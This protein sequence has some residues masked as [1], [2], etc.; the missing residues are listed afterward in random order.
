MADFYEC[1]LFKKPLLFMIE[2]KHMIRLVWN[3]L[4]LRLKGFMRLSG[5][6]P[7][8]NIKHLDTFVEIVIFFSVFPRH[9][10]PQGLFL[11]M[12]HSPVYRVRL[13]RLIFTVLADVGSP[14]FNGKEPSLFLI[15][16][17]FFLVLCTEV[18]T[19]TKII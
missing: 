15:S 5:N 11:L 19:K 8:I 3:P 4:Y 9:Q 14:L 2:V 12:H 7:N 1:L 18:C 16:P 17:V 13:S 10:H 6:Q